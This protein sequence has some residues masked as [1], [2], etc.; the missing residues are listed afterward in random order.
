MEKT[1][2]PAEK[3]QNNGIRD[4]SAADLLGIAIML[5]PFVIS[6]AFEK[7]ISKT[8]IIFKTGKEAVNIH[9]N[10]ITS[11][12]AVAFYAALLA[13]Y[14]I[15]RAGNIFEGIISS[16]RTFL[17]C[18]VLSSLISIALPAKEINTNTN[19]LKTLLQ[20]KE[21]TFF[22]LA[23]ILSWLG[24][25][26]IAGYSWIIFVLVACANMDKIS[27]HMG[28]WGALFIITLTISLFLQISSYSNIKDFLSDF[29]MPAANNP[30]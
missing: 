6:I 12:F 28:M 19:T 7:H 29:R 2:A 27:N 1:N 16:V 5:I 18:W 11:I 4:F 15:F 30:H 13:R 26:T 20:N 21:V 10:M 23:V 3:N 8:F 25:K 9:P 24:M 14:N 17:N 22:V